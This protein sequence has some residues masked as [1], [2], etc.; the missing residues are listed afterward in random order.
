[1]WPRL[2]GGRTACDKRC[3]L[4]TEQFPFTVGNTRVYGELAQLSDQSLMLPLPSATDLES[5][6]FE[7]LKRG[8][9]IIIRDAGTKHGT[10]VNGEVVRKYSRQ[11]EA[12]LEPGDN[13][14]GTGGVKS[15]V[16]FVVHLQEIG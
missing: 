4:I 12:V 6:H 13:I 3:F 2:V 5:P 16:T 14:V 15:R 8:S 9:D 11:V 7:I 10:V 1:M